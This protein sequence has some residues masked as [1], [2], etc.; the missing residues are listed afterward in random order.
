MLAGDRLITV[1][2]GEVEVAHEALLREWPRLRAWLEEDADGR[3]LHRHLTEAAR[4]WDA[5]G[6]D[7][8]ELYRGSRLVAALRVGGRPRRGPQ[9]R[10]SASSSPPRAPPRRPR[11]SGG[12]APTAACGRCWPAWRTLLV[13][14][15]VAGAIALS[16]RGQARDAA[17][18]ADAQRL[19]AEALTNERIDQA[20]LLARAGV[21]LDDSTA[22]RSN[23][24]ALLVR[25]PA[26][27][28]ELRGDGWPLY[29]L[30]LSDDDRLVAI[31][32]ERG[33]VIVYDTAT[34]RRLSRPY[35]A[36]DGGCV[37]GLAFSP[38]G[39]TLALAVHCSDDADGRAETFVDL[40]DPRTRRAPPPLRAAAAPE[41]S[42]SGR[43]RWFASSPTAAT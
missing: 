23:L 41:P 4:G 42:R 2:D 40:I 8:G 12:G 32:D 7:A 1:G 26:S 9:R 39:R 37:Q 35:A 19:G 14:A 25:E 18:A 38:D 33:A 20:L 16:Q 10:S 15:V 6:R 30:A 27:L 34:R 17:L 5:G 21:E 43:T 29:S 28:G 3:R 22:T 31:G 36:P 11:P 24:L 13:L